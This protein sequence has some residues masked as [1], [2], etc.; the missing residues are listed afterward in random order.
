VAAKHEANVMAAMM[1]DT[2]RA[3]RYDLSPFY[4]KYA[5]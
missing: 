4:E 1:S 3:K 2:N 5:L